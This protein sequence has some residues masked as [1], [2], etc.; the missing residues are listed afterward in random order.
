MDYDGD[1]DLDLVIS[2]ADVPSNGTWFFENP[3]GD[4]RMPVFKPAVRIDRGVR[5]VRVSIVDGTPRVLTP[6]RE[7]RDF[8]TRQFGDPAKLPAPPV[9]HKGRL[10]ANQWTY[11]DHDGDGRLDLIVGVGDWADYGWDNAFNPKGRW[12]RGPLHGYVY[13]LRNT[14]T[15]AKPAYGKPAKLEA[16]GKPI[17]VF[18][19]PSPSLADFDRDGD[20]DLL[21]GSF[22]DTLTYFQ[23]VGSRTQP[24][25]AAGRELVHEGRPLRM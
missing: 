6:G 14:G 1:G 20:F 21:C 12:T 8:R 3:G 9:V 16:G 19:M 13:L 18:G 25:Y 15:N 4:A 7:H 23:N 24:R 22:V 17:D 5:N 2:C 11:V 10:R